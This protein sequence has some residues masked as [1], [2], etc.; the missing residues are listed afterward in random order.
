[1]DEVFVVV[2]QDDSG[3]TGQVKAVFLGEEQAELHAQERT[4][5]GQPC[6]V[7][8][9]YL[10]DMTGGPERKDFFMARLELDD[11]GELVEFNMNGRPGWERAPEFGEVR[12]PMVHGRRREPEGWLVR[13]MGADPFDLLVAL[14][15]MR[16]A[17]QRGEDVEGV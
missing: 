4:R 1:M 2:S 11:Y 15:D 5:A 14:H 6:T 10:W 12:D 8:V 17:I 16:D 9:E 13:G 3:G 7:L